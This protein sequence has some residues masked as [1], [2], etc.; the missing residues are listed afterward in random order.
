[1]ISFG[2]TNDPLAFF[3]LMNEVFRDYLYIFV[4]VF[5]DDI[6]IYSTNENKHENYLRL[7]L[8]VL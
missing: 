3:D 8:K 7:A 2:L 1:M 5:I 6:F 4:I